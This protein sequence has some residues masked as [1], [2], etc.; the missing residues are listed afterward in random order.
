MK[1]KR[2]KQVASKA[3]KC[4]RVKTSPSSLR[5]TQE[6]TEASWQEPRTSSWTQFTDSVKI[7]LEPTAS[8]KGYNTTG[9]KGKN[10]LYEFVSSHASGH[11]L[12]EII[13]KAVRYGKKKDKN[14]ILKIAAWAYLIWKF[15]E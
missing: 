14:D 13:Y 8:E 10:E 12:G 3:D 11:A 4:R 15:D 1:N 6:A 2:V 7:L 9:V 5:V